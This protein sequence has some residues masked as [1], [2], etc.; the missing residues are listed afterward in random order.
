MHQAMQ[1]KQSTD[2][3]G[4]CTKKVRGQ[5]LTQPSRILE[6]AIGL[7][8]LVPV[9][10]VDELPVQLLGLLGVKLLAA[11]GALE[12]AA[13]LDA[14]ILDGAIARLGGG[15]DLH[16]LRHVEGCSL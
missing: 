16:G 10:V 13:G 11:V 6:S 5:G 4:H 7:V 12:G 15:S 8:L 2:V 1:E 3:S 14:N 9:G